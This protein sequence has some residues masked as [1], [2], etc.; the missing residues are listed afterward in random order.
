MIRHHLTG[1]VG[2]ALCGGILAGCDRDSANP[3]SARAAATAARQASLKKLSPIEIVR[4][5]RR[6]REDGRLLELYDYVAP[7]QGD[8][9]VELVQAVDRLVMANNALREEVE[10]HHGLGLAQALDRPQVAN[11][12]GVFSCDVTVVGESVSDGQAVVTYQVRERL[13]VNRVILHRYKNQWR[14]ETDPP[15]DGLAEQIRKLAG[16]LDSIAGHVRN[17]D[18]DARQTLEEWKLRTGGVMRK[19]EKLVAGDHD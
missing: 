9:V 1:L 4:K 12:I 11:I 8:A 10:T 3:P 6:A 18:Y 13:P 2:I 7:R 17:G 16:V 19:I 14:I 15:V 5:M